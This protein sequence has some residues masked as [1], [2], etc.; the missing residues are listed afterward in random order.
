MSV[1][2]ERL[3]IYAGQPSDGTVPLGDMLEIGELRNMYG[4]SL[5]VK[6]LDS[7]Q[8][9]SL[10]ALRSEKWV[11]LHSQMTFLDQLSLFFL[12]LVFFQ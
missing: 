2:H 11:C 10:H 3:A 12:D 4:Y 6:R 9:S 8:D 1:R 7:G 5:W